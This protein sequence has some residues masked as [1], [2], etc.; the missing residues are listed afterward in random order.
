MLPSYQSSQFAGYTPLLGATQLAGQLP[1]YGSQSLGTI[2]SLMG[3]YGTT[4]GTQPGGWGTDLISAGMAAL[5]FIP[6]I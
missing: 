5:P 2:G 6:G 1:Y 3:N 4:T